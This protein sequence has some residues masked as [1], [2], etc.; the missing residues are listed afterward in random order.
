MILNTKTAVRNLF[1][2]LKDYNDATVY[3]LSTSMCPVHRE[4]ILK[5]VREKLGKEPVICISTQLIEAG[6]DISFEAVFRSLAGLD[7]IAQAAGRCNRHAELELGDVYLF[8]SAEENLKFLPEIRVG[9][10]VMENYIL[11][12]EELAQQLLQPKVI[13]RYFTYFHR[14]AEREIM[15]NPGGLD[16]PLIDLINGRLQTNVSTIS[17]SSFK[18]LE[19]YFE[20]IHSPTT[21]VLVP[22]DE[23]AK[24]MIALLN[25]ELPLE[26]LNRYMKLAQRYAVNLFDYELAMLEKEGLIY[27][28][29]KEGILAVRDEGYSNQYGVS[30]EGEGEKSGLLF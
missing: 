23:K 12:N 27:P 30:F 8:K 11:P 22:Y 18:T 6:V 16:L 25:E 7:S 13:E 10:E 29:L 21:S 24:N 15:K 28:L 14:Q 9:A 20:A 5:E 2:A 19:S 17:R 1:I 4:H 26:E 3:H